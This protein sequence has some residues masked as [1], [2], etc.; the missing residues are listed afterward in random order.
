MQDPE[1]PI[2]RTFMDNNVGVRQQLAFMIGNDM[3]Q[4][5]FLR[6]S[7]NELLYITP[8]GEEALQGIC[9]RIFEKKF[10]PD[11]LMIRQEETRTSEKS[12]AARYDESS[13]TQQTSL[14]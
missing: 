5:G 7:E 10:H 13:G 6:E 1:D 3:K 4:F 9:R 2:E 14:F 11:M 8:K 12:S